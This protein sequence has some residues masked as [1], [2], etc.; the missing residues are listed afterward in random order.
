M[1]NDMTHEIAILF[2]QGYMA[3]V[4]FGS[5][6]SVTLYK[7]LEKSG[8]PRQFAERQQVPTQNRV[9]Q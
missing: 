2:F 3:G 5:I 1:E 9:T 4:V 8:N 7:Y 6:S